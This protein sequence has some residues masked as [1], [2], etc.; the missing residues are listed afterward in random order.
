M[1]LPHICTKQKQ[2]FNNITRLESIN[3]I[4]FIIFNELK[5]FKK[6]T[7]EIFFIKYKNKDIKEIYLWLLWFL[8]LNMGTFL[9]SPLASFFLI[10]PMGYMEECWVP[11]GILVPCNMK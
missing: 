5:N 2:K 11:V 1:W 3:T 6:F 7:L 9:F 8:L 4:L 10:Y